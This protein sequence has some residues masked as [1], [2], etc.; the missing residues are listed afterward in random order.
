HGVHL[1]LS[2]Q[3]PDGAVGEGTADFHAAHIAND[4]VIGRGFQPGTNGGIRALDQP[5]VYPTDIVNEIHADGQIWATAVWEF[6]VAMIA[7]HGDWAG[8]RIAYR[9]F[10]KAL[11]QNPTLTTAYPAIISGDDDDN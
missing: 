1:S 9:T 11:T 3:Q 8:K 4:P 7:K 2:T 5:K 6:R 10:L